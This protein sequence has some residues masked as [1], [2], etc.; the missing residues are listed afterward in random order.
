MFDIKVG[1]FL[2]Y[3]QV[4]NRFD[5]H[6]SSRPTMDGN[7]EQVEIPLPLSVFARLI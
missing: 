4:Y 1:A 6:D 7:S 2:Y 5:T 3:T